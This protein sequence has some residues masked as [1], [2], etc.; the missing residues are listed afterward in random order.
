[1]VPRDIYS[2]YLVNVGNARGIYLSDT[3]LEVSVEFEIPLQSPRFSGGPLCGCAEG[4]GCSRGSHPRPL[5]LT[6]YLG[7]VLYASLNTEPDSQLQ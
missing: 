1:M 3:V 2:L 4:V 5:S 7:T 6:G